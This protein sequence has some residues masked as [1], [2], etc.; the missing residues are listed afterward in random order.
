M[1]VKKLNKFRPALLVLLIVTLG[2]SFFQ[3]PDITPP[4]PTSSPR[5]Q[6]PYPEE[7]NWIVTSQSMPDRAEERLVPESNALWEYPADWDTY[8]IEIYQSRTGYGASDIRLQI[9]LFGETEVGEGNCTTQWTE[10]DG[11]TTSPDQSF[12]VKT[13]FPFWDYKEEEWSQY[14]FNFYLYCDPSLEQ[15]FFVLTE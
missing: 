12:F 7:F 6:N 4:A 14:Q 1:E 10:F 11:V 2:C 3:F 13:H 5:P 8:K 9:N 15:W